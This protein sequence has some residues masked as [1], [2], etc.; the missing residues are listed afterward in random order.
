MIKVGQKIRFDPFHGVGSYGLGACHKK[1]E[2]T[3]TMVYPEHRYFT[4]EYEMGERKFLISFNFVD[5]YGEKAFV[6]LVH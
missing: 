3:V 5:V 4:A 1:V 2:G 6:Q